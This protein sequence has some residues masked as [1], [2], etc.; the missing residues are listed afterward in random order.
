MRAISKFFTLDQVNKMIPLVDSIAVDVTNT[1]EEIMK[2]RTDLDRLDAHQKKAG[3]LSEQDK[4]RLS[5]TRADVNALVDRINTYIKELESLGI[6]VESYRCCI[7][8]FP[9]LYRGRKIQ[10]CYTPSVTKEVLFWHE[11]DEMENDRQPI[12]EEMRGALK[13]ID[14]INL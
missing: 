7:L 5:E 14:Y 8:D 3:D 10:L 11:L 9:A 6:Y 2:G 1:W 12:T 13:S 4:E